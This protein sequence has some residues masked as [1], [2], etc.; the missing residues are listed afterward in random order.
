MAI[1]IVI[2][3]TVGTDKQMRVTNL[4][5]EL[6]TKAIRQPGYVIVET[7]LSV[8]NPGTHIVINT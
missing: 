2:E 8:E 7:L 3:R 6:R 4:P 5:K 1:K